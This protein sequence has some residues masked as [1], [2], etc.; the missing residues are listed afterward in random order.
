MMK[1]SKIEN[2]YRVIRESNIE[3]NIL[4]VCFDENKTNENTIQIIDLKFPNIK[5]TKI[6][7]SHTELLDQVLN[8]LDS[9]NESFQTNYKLSKIYYV[10]SEDGSRFRYRN[11]THALI[12]HYH[13]GK[14]FKKY[15]LEANAFK[16]S[17]GNGFKKYYP[18]GTEVKK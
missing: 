5:D 11:L 17:Y 10:P 4:C 8:G 2:I 9:V 6:R 7:T 3:S 12:R 14:E 1:F 18:D 16:Y 15:N 13:E